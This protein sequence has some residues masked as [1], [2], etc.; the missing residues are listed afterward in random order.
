MLFRLNPLKQIFLLIMLSLFFFLDSA[1]AQKCLYISSYHQGY[2][3]SDGVEKGVRST[4]KDKCEFK[5]FNMDTKRNKEVSYKKEIAL[6]ARELIQSWQPDVII[7]SDDNAARYIIQP[8]YK[9]H[10]IP[11]VF[12]GINWN[13]DAY[14]FPYTN[15]TGMVEVAPITAL[16][17]KVSEISGHPSNAF[18]IGADTLTEKKNLARFEQEAADAHIKLEHG[19]AKDLNEWLYYYKKA[20]DYDFVIIGSHSGINDWDQSSIQVNV[21]KETSKLSVTNHRWM[22]PYTILGLTKIP[23]EQGI[24]AAQAALNILDGVN[25]SSI[26]IIANRK[27]DVWLNENILGKTKINM[28]KTLAKKAKK[29]ID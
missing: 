29:V 20:Q 23:E 1:I 4:L 8:Y 11:F 22:M 9:D 14:G 13:V 3:W 27:W 21:L 19:L 25:P 12:C 5:Q 26:P 6:K 7:A 17:D 10:S 2:E 16:F 28:P 24:W 18:Y 15:T